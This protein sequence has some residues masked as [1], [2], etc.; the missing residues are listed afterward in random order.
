MFGTLGPALAAATVVALAATGCAADT[1]AQ[2]DRISHRSSAA[3]VTSVV[4]VSIDGLNPAAI[5]RLGA[6]G[7]PTLHRLID[8]GASTLN[9]RTAREQTNTLPNHTGMLTGRRID[10][11]TGGHGVTWNDERLHPRTVHEAAGHR[12]ASVF[13]KVHSRGLGTALFASKGKFSLF[14]RSWER[15]IDRYLMQP[16]NTRLVRKVRADLAE[17]ERAFRFVHLSAPDGAGHAH[18]FMSP[19]YLDAVRATDRLLGRIVAKIEADPDLAR[20]V[21]LMVTADHGGEGVNHRDATKAY[22]YRVPFLVWGRGVKAGANLYRLN[23]DYA[24]PGPRRTHYSDDRQP[25]R[26][27]DV[28]NLTTDLLGLGRVRGSEHNAA[29]DLDVR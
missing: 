3:T 11:K 2:P 8:E 20:H 15:G 22:N 1:S 27:G 14:D 12:V 26:N 19:E 13:S 18:G 6:E 25:V 4:A 10:P 16:N 9:A 28:A 23:P 24:F 29:Q 5:R 17:H 7:T 21:V